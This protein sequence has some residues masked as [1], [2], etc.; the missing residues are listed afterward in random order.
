VIDSD[1]PALTGTIVGSG[2]E[3]VAAPRAARQY[4]R[5]LLDTGFV[6]AEVEVRT[7]VFTDPTVVPMLA[8][9]AEAAF[10]RLDQQSSVNLVDG[11]TDHA[12]RSRPTVPCKRSSL[13]TA[14]RSLVAQIS[15]WL[16]RSWRP[17]G[18]PKR[19]GD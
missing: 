11:A 10:C 15:S 12:G 18:A 4:R 16:S 14:S 8:G 7:G 3:L 6:D 13:M 19:P 9:F 5:L 2:A 17:A 1:D